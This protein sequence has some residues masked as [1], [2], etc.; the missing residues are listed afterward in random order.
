M[1]RD[2]SAPDPT[3]RRSLDQDADGGELVSGVLASLRPAGVVFDCDG[4]LMDT[5]RCWTTAETAVFAT[6]GLPYGP[7]EKGRFIGKSV[8]AS[9]LMMAEVFGEPGNEAAIEAEVLDRVED[10]L[11][12]EAEPMPGALQLVDLLRLRVPIAVAS[13]SPRAV[14][15]VTLTRAGLTDTFGAVVAA[16]EVP[17][18]KPGPDL[19][20]AACELLGVPASQCLAFE[21]ST[22]GVS[23]ARAAGMAVIAVPSPEHPALGADLVLDSLAHPA[24]VAWAA[25]L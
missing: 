4:L 21:D 8:P 17:V 12:R 7:A 9:A 22:T 19:Y 23:A 1:S 25:S 24:L 6:R 14:L 11:L 10:V 13:N 20:L 16:D 2:P 5:E 15:D 18:P 3:P